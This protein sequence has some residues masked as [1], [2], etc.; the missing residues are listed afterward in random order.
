MSQETEP[1]LNQKPKDERDELALLEAKVARKRIEVQGATNFG[2]FDITA[3]NQGEESYSTYIEQRPSDGVIRDTEG[4]RQTKTGQFAAETAYVEQT[5][6]K[7]EILDMLH[8]PG[9][10]AEA[11]YDTM[12]RME[13]IKAA[14]DAKVLGDRAELE[15]IRAAFEHNLMEEFTREISAGLTEEESKTQGLRYEKTKRTDEQFNLELAQFD[16][17]IDKLLV[18]RSQKN[19]AETE[20]LSTQS[21]TSEANEQNLT[22]EVSEQALP[23]PERADKLVLFGVGDIVKVRR[24]SGEIE[25]GWS[26]SNYYTDA[27]GERTY[28]VNKDGLRKP[29][30]PEDE[31]VEWQNSENVVAGA[32]GSDGEALEGESLEEYELRMAME[33]AVEGGPTNE[34]AEAGTTE[35]VSGEGT[36]DG[37][38]PETEASKLNKLKASWGNKRDAIK[39]FLRPSRIAASW[40]TSRALKRHEREDMTEEERQKEK[41]RNRV[42]LILGGF[43]GGVIVSSLVTKGIIDASTTHTVLGQGGNTPGSI[44][45]LHNG[46]GTGHT[47]VESGIGGAAAGNIISTNPDIIVR[48]GE[49]GEALLTRLGVQHPDRVWSTIQDQ[50]L[51]S[52]PTEFY[53]EG[54]EMVRITRPGPLSAQTQ[55]I[56]NN[57]IGR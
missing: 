52:S 56:I 5:A 51:R 8:N 6:P 10:Q 48:P 13:L 41:R 55:A 11:H 25:E 24:T 30:I 34:T 40:E 49:G 26:V 32:H 16:T 20:K 19:R 21:L 53:K 27:F 38:E 50:L 46:S 31:L 29:R 57:A 23:S 17:E 15:D 18:V 12:S 28:D 33:A 47:T 36:G 7:N 35:P 14:A 37:G 45:A 3:P 44:D 54:A 4:F 1:H 43:A 39:D 42:L 22:D 2:K 9:E